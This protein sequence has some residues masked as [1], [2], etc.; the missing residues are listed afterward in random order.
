M[1]MFDIL[2]RS[3]WLSFFIVLVPTG[4]YTVHNGSSAVVAF[5]WYAVLSFVIPL[6]YLRSKSSAM[7]VPPKRI[8]LW[9]FI[10]GWGLVQVGTYG[11]FQTQDLSWLW[12]FTTIGRD[13]VFVITMYIQVSLALL[14]A[15]VLSRLIGDR[16][17]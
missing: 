13:F 8:A 5:I 17:E 1:K 11:F 7:G 14:I 12:T 15:Y 3:F 2:K 4:V 10:I 9:T 6:L 16:N